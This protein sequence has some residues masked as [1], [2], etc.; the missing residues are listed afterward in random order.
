MFADVTSNDSTNYF[1]PRCS[2]LHPL[3]EISRYNLKTLPFRGTGFDTPGLDSLLSPSSAEGTFMRSNTKLFKE[4]QTGSL[5]SHVGKS[6]TP[7]HAI[8]IRMAYRVS[9]CAPLR[10]CCFNIWYI[11]W[12]PPC[13]DQRWRQPWNASVNL[14]TQRSNER[15]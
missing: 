7:H 12:G 5:G 11:L 13:D 6:L 2:S 10:N 8:W 4:V 3:S 9:K 1:P 15:K 14:H